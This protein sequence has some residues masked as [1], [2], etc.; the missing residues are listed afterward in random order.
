MNDP[1]AKVRQLATRL[2]QE[3][4]KI[5]LRMTTFAVFPSPVVEGDDF[6]EGVFTIT[7]QGLRTEGERALDAAFAEIISTVETTEPVNVMRQDVI[8]KIDDILNTEEDD[9]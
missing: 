2:K 8:D 4:E 1:L 6:A 7:P 5:G 3:S 9:L